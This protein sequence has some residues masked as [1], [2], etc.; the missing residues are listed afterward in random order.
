MLLVFWFSVFIKRG[1]ESL[2]NF[3]VGVVFHFLLLLF[4]IVVTFR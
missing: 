4:W 3:L 1:E 2:F